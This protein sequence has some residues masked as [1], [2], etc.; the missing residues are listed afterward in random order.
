MSSDKGTCGPWGPRRRAADRADRASVSVVCV[1]IFLPCVCKNN[2]APVNRS[3]ATLNETGR[4]RLCTLRLR[5]NSR[6]R[7][8]APTPC[9]GKGIVFSPFTWLL[10]SDGLWVPRQLRVM[11]TPP[12]PPP[13]PSTNSAGTEC[14]SSGPPVN[15][16]VGAG[17]LRAFWSRV[18]FQNLPV[19][20]RGLVPS[21]LE[22]EGG[23][24]TPSS[25][26]EPLLS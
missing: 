12:S 6:V 23:Y 10:H 20:V 3:E 14:V 24:M 16:Q 13:Q 22:P 26:R 5:V 19:P 4:L 15:R 21:P 17:L 18:L 11:F 25:S 7:R 2:A 1:T 9:V 8:S